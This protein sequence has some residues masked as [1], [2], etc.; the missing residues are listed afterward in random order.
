SKVM[1][2]MGRFTA[3]GFASGIDEGARQVENAV[4]RMTGLVGRGV[5]GDAGAY[6]AWNLPPAAAAA[7]S[8]DS[9]SQINATIVMDKRVVGS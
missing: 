9:G 4:D 5:R 8:R 2:Q 7:G 3:Q 6:A 1:A